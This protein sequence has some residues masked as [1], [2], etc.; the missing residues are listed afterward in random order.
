VAAE[1]GLAVTQISKGIFSF[2]PLAARFH[3][4]QLKAKCVATPVQQPVRRIPFFARSWLE[5]H[6]GNIPQTL[7][8][9]FRYAVS[10]IRKLGQAWV[11]AILRT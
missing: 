6:Q 9:I 8:Y 10:V 1:V 2:N 11:P 3:A 5:L 4:V 7:R